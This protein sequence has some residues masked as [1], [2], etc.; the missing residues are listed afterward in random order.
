LLPSIVEGGNNLFAIAPI[1]GIS[2]KRIGFTQK[3]RGA[4][5]VSFPN[6]ESGVT[7]DDNKETIT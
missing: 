6:Q 4:S 2:K 7:S 5:F 3:Y 1:A